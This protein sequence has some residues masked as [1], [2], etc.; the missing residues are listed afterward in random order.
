MAV[1]V[2]C[3]RNHREERAEGEVLS[4]SRVYSLSGSRK[5]PGVDK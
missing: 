5:A 1:G 2:G 3:E 4:L